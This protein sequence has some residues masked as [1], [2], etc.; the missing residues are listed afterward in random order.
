MQPVRATFGHLFTDEGLR[1]RTG[2]CLGCCVWNRPVADGGLAKYRN[3]GLSGKPDGFEES[4]R[5]V[6]AF[7]ASASDDKVSCSAASRNSPWPGHRSLTNDREN[8]HH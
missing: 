8:R 7:A 5:I 4:A 6:E 2:K 3:K 1:L